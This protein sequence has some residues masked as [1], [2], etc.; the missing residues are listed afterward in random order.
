MSE[1]TQAQLRDAARN[2][3]WQQV[4]LNLGP[5]CFFYEKERGLFCLRAKRWDGHGEPGFHHFVS[6]EKL[7]AERS[8]APATP[9]TEEMVHDAFLRSSTRIPSRSE[10]AGI[11]AT[12][13]LS[14]A[15]A[16]PATQTGDV[17]KLQKILCAA[18]Q[19]D[20]LIQYLVSRIEPLLAGS[21]APTPEPTGAITEPPTHCICGNRLWG[22]W[23][24]LCGRDSRDT[25][26]AQAG[27]KMTETEAKDFW[28]YLDRNAEIVRQWPGWMR[29]QP[30]QKGE[31]KVSES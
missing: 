1:P 16:P 26:A 13:N 9:I 21:A 11:A 31:R 12:L 20:V 5:P 28:A 15:A 6:L 2:A 19:D 25:L 7:L 30:G 14:L 4:V 22:F 17:R 23:V 18:I 27:Q 8:L 24:C 29:G 10:S 3:D